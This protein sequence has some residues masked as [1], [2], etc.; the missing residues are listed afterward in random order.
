M[1]RFKFTPRKWAVF[2][3]PRAKEVPYLVLNEVAL[4]SVRL[5]CYLRVFLDTQFLLEKQVAAVTE[6][7][8]PYMHYVYKLCL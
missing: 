5:V 7:A 3:T 8:F 4:S 2:G 1:N 6:D